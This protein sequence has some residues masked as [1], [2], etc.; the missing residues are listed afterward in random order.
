MFIYLYFIAIINRPLI[1]LSLNDLHVFIEKNKL[2]S[3]AIINLRVVN[4]FLLTIL[5]H[6]PPP[7]DRSPPI[8]ILKIFF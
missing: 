6:R 1:V 3:F 5:N 7:I 4:Q 8:G 2:H